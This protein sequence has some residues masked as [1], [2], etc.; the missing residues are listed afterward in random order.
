M[1][2]CLG[3]IITITMS[4]DF[5]ILGQRSGWGQDCPFGLS[6]EDRLRHL[7]IVGKTGTGKTTLLRNLVLQDLEAGR[8]LALLDPHGDLA[9]DLLDHIPPWRTDHV[10]YFNPT[11]HEFPIGINLLQRVDPEHRHLVA[12]GIVS[13]FKS[14]WHDSWGPR[15][16]YILYATVAA[17]LDV[18]NATL[19]GVQRML[20]HAPYRRWVVDQIRDP[21]VRA[22]W[23]DEFAHYDPR[24]MREAIAPIQNKV[25]QLLMAS[26]IRNILGQVRSRVDLGFTM[27][28]QRILIANL[29]KGRLG[30]DKSNLLGA[31]LIAQFQ[32]AAMG[33]ATVAEEHRQ[34]FCLYID[35]FHNFTTDSFSSILSE[36]RKY[37]LGLT[38]AHQYTGQ[39]PEQTRDAVFGNVGTMVSFRVGHSDASI[40][41]RE[42]GSSYTTSHFT[43]LSNHEIRVRL[44]QDGDQRE[45]FLGRTM[46]PGSHSYGRR[47]MVVRRSR[48][49]Y[50]TPREVVEDK[51]RRWMRA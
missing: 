16:E 4:D 50:G 30:Q 38:L 34:D 47:D 46:A 17:L 45:P 44:M 2:A 31:A 41:A 10:A 25:G 33:R 23:T 29:S 32:L 7:Y 26:P 51:I 40:L 49:R 24:F 11:D 28:N 9:E 18:E 15:M 27:D 3:T 20:S 42:F 19:L 48:E 22:F 35:E 13:I 8:G 39:L 1:G 12:S 6:R 14:I 5:V 36:A 43:D 37:R 21:I